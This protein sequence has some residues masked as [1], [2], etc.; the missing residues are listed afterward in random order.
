MR[1]VVERTPYGCTEIEI[2]EW[3]DI[4]VEQTSL[5]GAIRGVRLLVPHPARTIPADAD[6]ALTRCPRGQSGGVR[7]R[8]HQIVPNMAS[9]VR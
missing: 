4:R 6:T 1:A 7:V 3:N 9:H 8:S 2:F 5:T